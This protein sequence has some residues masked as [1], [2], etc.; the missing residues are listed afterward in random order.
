[1]N[2]FHHAHKAQHSLALQAIDMLHYLRHADSALNGIQ[3]RQAAEYL[4][5]RI[6]FLLTEREPGHFIIG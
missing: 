2:L 1:M 4:H 3:Q 6:L 5:I